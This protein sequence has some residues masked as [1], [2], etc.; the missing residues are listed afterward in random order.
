MLPEANGINPTPE[1]RE[2]PLLDKLIESTRQRFFAQESIPSQ[3]PQRNQ[4]PYYGLL[5]ASD[6]IN[7]AGLDA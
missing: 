3:N 4:E 5:A 2:Q 6:A 1:P 7:N